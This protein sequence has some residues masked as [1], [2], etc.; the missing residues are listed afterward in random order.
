VKGERQGRLKDSMMTLEP[1]GGCGRK[2]RKTLWGTLAL[3]KKDMGG[4]GRIMVRERRESNKKTIEKPGMCRGGG[5][6]RSLF[7]KVATS[8]SEEGLQLEDNGRNIYATERAGKGMVRID[9]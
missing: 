3:V 6:R 2:K 1:F 5:K 4:I 9:C 8:Y 7:S